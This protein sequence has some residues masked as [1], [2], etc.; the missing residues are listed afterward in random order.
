MENYIHAFG[1]YE[2][3]IKTHSQINALIFTCNC[4][5]HLCTVEFG[6]KGYILLVSIYILS[7][8]YL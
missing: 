2:V 5:F 6:F 7:K 4:S 3:S 1:L 8:Y